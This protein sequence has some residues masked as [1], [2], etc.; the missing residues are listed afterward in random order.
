MLLDSAMW[1]D[2]E[3]RTDRS[4]MNAIG[5]ALPVMLLVSGGP[6]EAADSNPASRSYR[7]GPP[8]STCLRKIPGSELL[9]LQMHQSDSYNRVGHEISPPPLF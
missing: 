1:D 8:A 3:K 9:T 4:I 7:Y 5:V 2:S 6:I